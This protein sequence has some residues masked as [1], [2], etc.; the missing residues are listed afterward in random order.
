[1]KRFISASLALAA[2]AVVGA[3]S[4]QAAP[5]R[6]TDAQMDKVAAGGGGAIVILAQFVF[7]LGG[8]GGGA[9]GNSD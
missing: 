9:G 2:L 8:G 1:M 7:N 6:L 3:T 5:L 4:A